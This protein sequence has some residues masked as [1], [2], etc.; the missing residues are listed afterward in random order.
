MHIILGLLLA[1]ALIALYHLTTRTSRRCRWRA[2]RSKDRDGQHYHY[3]AACGAEQMTDT[4]N[5]PRFCLAGR[6]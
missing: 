2:D 6:L 4:P 1:F 5:A 3:C